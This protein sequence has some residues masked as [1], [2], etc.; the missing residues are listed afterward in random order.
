MVLRFEYLTIEITA[1]YM[2]RLR[3]ITPHGITV[4]RLAYRIPY[5]RGLHHVLKQL[6]TKRGV[7][8]SSGY[9]YR[10]VIRAGM[11]PVS[12]RRLKSL[13][14]RALSNSARSIGAAKSC[15]PCSSL[16]SSPSS[17]AIYIR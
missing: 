10:S 2:K 9:E 1:L 11:W 13:P 8:L 5:E 16:I 12:H 3:Y 4:T 15:C 14:A 17:R 7:Y 6:D